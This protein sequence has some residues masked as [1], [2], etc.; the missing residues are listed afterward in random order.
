M[1]LGCSTLTSFAYLMSEVVLVE[2]ASTLR[3]LRQARYSWGGNR[4]ELLKSS[5]SFYEGSALALLADFCG[6]R[7]VKDIQ[8]PMMTLT[9]KNGQENEQ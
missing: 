9:L 6:M 8:F 2:V 7:Q 4:R 5:C 3:K 1:K